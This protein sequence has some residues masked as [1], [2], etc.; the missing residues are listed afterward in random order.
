M[1]RFK[2]LGSFPAVR[3]LG[4]GIWFLPLPEGLTVQTWQIF[5]NI[6]CTIITVIAN[7]SFSFSGMRFT[8]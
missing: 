7:L 2:K 5:A 4:L 1:K 3:V 6:I 8:L